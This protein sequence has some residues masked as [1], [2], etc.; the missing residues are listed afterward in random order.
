MNIHSFRRGKSEYM[1]ERLWR[2]TLLKSSFWSL[3]FKNYVVLGHFG[4]VTQA[5]SP[6]TISL[7]LVDVGAVSKSNGSFARY[8]RN[9]V[10]EIRLP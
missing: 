3:F 6:P 2:K 4:V 1:A 7:L 10:S 5:L 8:S 9:L